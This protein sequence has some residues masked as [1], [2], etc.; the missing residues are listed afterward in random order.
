MTE[1]TLKLG[2]RIASEIVMMQDKLKRAETEEFIIFTCKHGS[3]YV[4]FNFPIQN[5][6]EDLKA[7]AIRYAKEELESLQ[8]Q[9]D[10]L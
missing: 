8:K 5:F 6:Y 10:S 4:I 1:E 3:A 9:F 7:S 2:N